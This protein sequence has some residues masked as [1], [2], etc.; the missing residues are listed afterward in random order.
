VKGVASIYAHSHTHTNARKIIKTPSERKPMP[1]REKGEARSWHLSSSWCSFLVSWESAICLKIC[2]VDKIFLEESHLSRLKAL[3]T[4]SV[5]NDIPKSMEELTKHIGDNDV[6][7]DGWSDITREVID[8]ASNLRMISVW[9]TGHDY[10]DVQ[11]A[12]EK[13]ITVTNVPGY[14]SQAVAE[15]TLALLFAVAK[16]IPEADRFVKSGN[17]GW[18]PFRSIELRGR[19]MGVIGTGHIG[20]LV[21]KFAQCLGMEVI[22]YTKHP[23]AER[24][25]KLGVRF[26]DLETLLRRSDVISI[27]V[28]ANDETQKLIGS[29]QLELVKKGVI[30][31]NT[32]RGKIIDQD[33]LVQALRDGVVAGA[34]IDSL[35][36]EPPAKD[37]PLFAME[38][39]VLTPHVAFHTTEALRR[40]TDMCIANIE[41]WI[42]RT[43]QNVVSKV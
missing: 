42:R 38:N 33:A 28:P 16:R 23:S 37:N 32:A 19:T 13:G 43:P 26:V 22:A 1:F 5:Y 10:I 14:A 21:A 4:I 34:G 7:I 36:E 15:H 41:N 27:H 25:R 39:V 2:V 24:A 11:A 17:W 20:E 18:E 8:K 3:G 31:I 12:S 35:Q 6:I 40:C 30:I 29:E 9:A